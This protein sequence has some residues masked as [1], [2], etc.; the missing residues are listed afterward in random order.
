MY[1]NFRAMAAH[2][3]ASLSSGIPDG[4]GILDIK[5]AMADLGIDASI[6]EKNNL[7]TDERFMIG[8][9]R[10][11]NRSDYVFPKL[12]TGWELIVFQRNG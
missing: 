1:L 4:V 7:T 9:M 6:Y 12:I 10:M 3:N 5:R 8:I 11:I 2:F